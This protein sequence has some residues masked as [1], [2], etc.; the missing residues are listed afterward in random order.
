MPYATRS[1]K[2]QHQ[3][4]RSMQSNKSSEANG[5]CIAARHEIACRAYDHPS[6]DVIS[7]PPE[8]PHHFPFATLPHQPR[9][10]LESAVE[11]EPL[12]SH[13]WGGA[14]APSLTTYESA[15]PARRG[16]PKRAS[17]LEA[18]AYSTV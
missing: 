2:V 14:T 15:F 7:A 4:K 5:V 17:I 16:N 1:T 12:P 11:P 13:R 9:L 3:C 8:S 10:V 18:L 6:R